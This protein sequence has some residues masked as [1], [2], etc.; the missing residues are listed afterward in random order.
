MRVVC[1]TNRLS[2]Q[3]S[4]NVLVD[5]DNAAKFHRH[6]TLYLFFQLFENTANAFLKQNCPGPFIAFGL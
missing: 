3:I 4:S 5:I 2:G 6:I 1:D